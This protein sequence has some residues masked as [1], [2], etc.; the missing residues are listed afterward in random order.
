MNLSIQIHKK[1]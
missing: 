1:P